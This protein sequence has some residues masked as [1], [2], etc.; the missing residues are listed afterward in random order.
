MSNKWILLIYGAV[1][2]TLVSSYDLYKD[3]NLLV[4]IAVAVVTYGG[5]AAWL[6]S[7]RGKK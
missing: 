1:F 4:F 6:I 3:N 7:S 5:L 2:F